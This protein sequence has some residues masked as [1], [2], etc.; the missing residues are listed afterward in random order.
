MIYIKYVTTLSLLS[1]LKL[2]CDINN[3]VAFSTMPGID[4]IS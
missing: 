1:H 2:E 3:E 4:L